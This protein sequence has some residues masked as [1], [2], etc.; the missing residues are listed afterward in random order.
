M[1]KFSILC[2]YTNSDCKRLERK[3]VVMLSCYLSALFSLLLLY[4]YVHRDITVIH[5]HTI[6]VRICQWSAGQMQVNQFTS[7][8]LV[9]YYGHLSS[10]QLHDW[11]A[12]K[13][14][15]IIDQCP[16]EQTAYRREIKDNGQICLFKFLTGMS[17]ET[18]LDKGI[19]QKSTKE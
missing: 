7:G 4:M 14:R 9:F 18:V 3:R 1:F 16:V 13:Q 5:V 6:S 2:C 15:P 19:R 12:L 8:I 10:A 17:K 11:Q